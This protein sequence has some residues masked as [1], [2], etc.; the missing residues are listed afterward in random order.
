MQQP[1]FEM[2]VSL[3]N[4]ITYPVSSR[5]CINYEMS[6]RAELTE[7]GTISAS[8]LQIFISAFVLFKTRERSA[9]FQKVVEGRGDGSGTPDTVTKIVRRSKVAAETRMFKGVSQPQ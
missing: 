7:K 4:Q 1:F 3:H 6:L 9:T 8:T 5:A 2:R